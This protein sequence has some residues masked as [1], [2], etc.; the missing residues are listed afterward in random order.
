M[1]LT[2]LGT[3]CMVPTKDRNV[4]G[5]FLSFKNQGILFDCGEG[6][7]RQMN[8]CGLKRSCITKILIT[9]WHGDHIGGLI[10]LLHTISNIEGSQFL[11]LYG[12]KGTKEKMDYLKKLAEFKYN[13]NCKVIE[14]DPSDVE[15]FYEDDEFELWCC[16]G[17]HG[18]PVLS[19]AFVEKDRLN[20]DKE[21][22]A[23]HRI[24]PGPHMKLLKQGKDI[25]YK[26]KDIKAEDIIYEVKGK[27]I[28]YVTDTRP[29]KFAVELAEDSDILVADAT[30][31]S[32]FKEKAVEHYHM[33]AHEA[34]SLANQ[35]GVK[36]LYLTHFSQRYKTV[37]LLEEEARTIF[38]NSICAK[39]LMKIRL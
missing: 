32:E 25:N 14:L 15:V 35:A 18:T 21:K 13:L 2:F 7:Q 28:S 3:S 19:Y 29:N 9:H 10:G 37:D 39:D 22:L 6:T 36:K 8:L 11:E 38:D 5:L 30:Y 24:G 26:G 4:S 1:E 34:A 16:P 17:D 12:P 20:L 31:A 33:T 23:R 27:K